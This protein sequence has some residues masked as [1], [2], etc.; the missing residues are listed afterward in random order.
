MLMPRM[1]TARPPSRWAA[2][3]RV[4]SPPSTTT[5][6]ESRPTAASSRRTSTPLARR[7]R[8]TWRAVSEASAE[9]FFGRCRPGAAPSRGGIPFAAI[10]IVP[11]PMDLFDHAARP[12]RRLEAARR[13]AAPAPPRRVRRPGAPA[14]PRQRAAPRHRGRPGA[15]AHALGPPGHREDHAGPHR[16][17]ARPAP[18]SRPFSAVLGGREGAP[19]DRGRGRRAAPPPP[20]SAPSSS[21]TRSTA[22]TR[23][24]RTPSAPRRGGHHHA[25]RRHHREPVA[26]RST[27]RSSR[28]AG[29]DPARAS[30]TR[31]SGAVLDRGGGLA[32]R[33]RRRRHGRRRGPRPSSPARPRRR[34][35]GAH[36]AR[37]GRRAV[38]WPGARRSR[39]PTP[40]RRCSTSRS[41][42]TRRGEEHYNVVSAPSSSRCAARTPTRR[43]TGWRGCSRPGE[44]P[45]FIVRRMV[46]FASEDVGNAD[47]RA[48]QVATAALQA[49]EL[50]GLP[51][52]RCSP[53]PRPSPTWPSPPSRT[54]V[55]TTYATARRL[56]LRAGPPPR[57]APPAQRAHAAH[58]V[59]G[60]R[61]RLPL[62][63]RLRGHFVPEEY[64]PGGAARRA[65][66]RALRQRGREGALRADRAP[67]R[68][69]EGRP[70]R[71][72]RYAGYLP[73]T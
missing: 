57:A 38:A 52:G 53:S 33:A 16:R 51:R 14:R 18:P 32:A 17:R 13:A 54:R 27:P 45:R 9:V 8:S 42:T 69:R 48:L 30:R 58:E 50:V 11:A 6:S 63:A 73:V 22:S 39:P 7:K 2:W 31:S 44:D 21:S 19:G 40:R 5:R 64:L 26:S 34:A 55:I 35:A 61:R 49:L 36:R 43:S 10:Y 24:S 37:V 12:G 62:P 25:H 65:L 23:P 41:S 59:D 3:M 67:A 29:G 1:G 47:P 56:V 4:P 15:L 70:R 72:G 28:A 66:L 60:L 46:I 71:P 68:G 20:A